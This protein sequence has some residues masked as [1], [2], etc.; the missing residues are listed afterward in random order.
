MAYPVGCK[1]MKILPSISSP[2]DLKPLSIK[3]L[4]QVCSE[5][6]EYII[7]VVSKNGGHLASNLGTIELT[8]V[9]HN[10]FNAPEDLIIWDVGHQTYA[11][12]IITG[13]YS[14]FATLRKQDGISG[15]PSFEESEYD[16]FITGHSSTSIS[17]AAGLASAKDLKKENNTIVCII[18]DASLAGGMAFEALNHIGHTG[19]DVIVI[20]N[21]N[22]HSISASVGALSKYLI[23]IVTNPIINKARLDIQTIVKRIPRFGSSAYRAAL[24][25]EKNLYSLLVPGLLFEELGFRY[26]G[27]VDGHNIELLKLSLERI[28]S[29]KGPVLLHCLTKK[30]KGYEPAEKNP[31]KFHSVPPFL[32]QTGERSSE[33]KITFTNV[34][35]NALLRQAEMDKRIVA[36]SA[37][38]PDGTGTKE[39]SFLYPDRFF[40]VG[41]AEQ[42]AIGFAAGLAR[43]GFKPVVAIYSTFLQRGYDQIIHDIALQKLPVIF[44][45]DRAGIVGEDGPTHNGI[46]DIAYLRSIPGLNLV[47]PKDGNE[48]AQMF[49][50]ALSL[51]EPVAIRFPKAETSEETVSLKIE[52][53][54]SEVIFD[55]KDVALVGVGVTTNICVQ[56]HNL[57]KNKNISSA[58]INLRFISPIDRQTL[59]DFAIRTKKIVVVED[60][61]ISGG[62]GSAVLEAVSETGA[63]IKIIGVHG[64]VRHGKRQDVLYQEGISVDRIVN[65]V[66]K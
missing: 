26:I 59:M 48:L 36:I 28:K 27:P 45:I 7:D 25:L 52:K 49:S 30:G 5:I 17:W 1:R 43:Q 66:L 18:G 63:Q 4:Q 57:L 13:R 35:S 22:E 33:K 44:I 47:A 14:K 2:S 3:E 60:G 38:M 39:F 15:F 56:A 46:F 10:V 51:N 55:G 6:R 53:A 37:A 31:E 62:A 29:I 9:L 32:V 54:K 19:K 16:L 41:I 8:V 34:F 58:V 12:K 11:H 21:D 50:F 23:K 24:K 20:L 64:F 65:E 40:D 42:H 61:I